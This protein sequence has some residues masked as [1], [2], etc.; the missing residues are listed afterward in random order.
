[1]SYGGAGYTSVSSDTV[2]EY[3]SA[4]IFSALAAG[5]IGLRGSK[6]A[7]YVNSVGND[8]SNGDTGT[9]LFSYCGD[10]VN[11]GTYKI[12]CYDAI[13]DSVFATPFV[14]GVGALNADNTKST[15][16]TPGASLWVSAY[17]GEYGITNPAITTVDR[18]SCSKGYN[19]PSGYRVNPLND[20]QN[21]HP[22]NPDCNYTNLMNG[23]SSA[24]P[25]V[26]GV[27]ALMLEANSDLTWRDVKHI[28]AT[29]SLQVDA[30]F[31]ATAVNTI[32]YV[33]W[34][35]NST[36]LKFHPW[37]GFGAIDATA[38]VNAA[39]SYTSGILGS[40][41]FSNWNNSNVGYVSLGEGVLNTETIAEN[42]SGTVEH[43]LVSLRVSHSDPTH[44]GF[45]LE[46]PDGTISTLLPPLTALGTDFSSSSWIY[47][48]SN[49]FYGES[50]A[51]DWK[52]HI[53]DHYSGSTGTLVQWG[54][55]FMYR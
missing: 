34:I 46:S 40:H 52:L 4:T 26:S 45:R 18:S 37:Y 19:S 11:S 17:G 10:G 39:L 7:L 15:Y 43:V 53:Y 21:P 12:G 30:N 27:I 16:S 54:L 8:Y 41:S 6:G 22:E 20:Y 42:G 3:P 5:T 36:G 35:T 13:F 29:T 47:L 55:Q 48:P 31:S 9:G 49:A 38:A 25:M 28:L 33:G 32:P 44:L 1:M 14:I 2:L 23:T 50:K 51:G 24:A